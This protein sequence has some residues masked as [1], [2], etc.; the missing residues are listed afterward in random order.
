MFR[1]SGRV[2]LKRPDSRSGW[3]ALVV[4]VCYTALVN[5]YDGI[6]FAHL[7]FHLVFFQI[8]TEGLTGLWEELCFRG[9]LM[10]ILRPCGVF[11]SVLISSAVFGLLHVDPTNDFFQFGRFLVT[12]TLGLMFAV[13]RLQTN[14][15]LPAVI[16]HGAV[17]AVND[18]FSD[19]DQS[20]DDSISTLNEEWILVLVSVPI[21]IYCFVTI[22]KN[23]SGWNER[24]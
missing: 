24:A 9:F 13:N 12:A 19:S 7:T 22:R 2:G 16:A 21:L 14:S 23:F 1:C 17:N 4:L 11:G 18:L 10:T 5:L 3:V 8:L 20:V 15:I 6:F